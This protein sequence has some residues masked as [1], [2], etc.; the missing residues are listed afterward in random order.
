LELLFV[1]L[2]IVAVA[3]VASLGIYYR[4]RSRRPEGSEIGE[5]QPGAFAALRQEYKSR[6]EDW[7]EELGLSIDASDFPSASVHSLS[8]SHLRLSPDIKGG[9]AAGGAEGAALASDWA[10]VDQAVL[11]GYARYVND[12][13]VS[14]LDLYRDA[15]GR[16][17][18]SLD[19]WVNGLRG[20]VAEQ[21]VFGQLGSWIGDGLTIPSSGSF[22]GVDATILGTD[23]N[24]KAT[25]DVSRAAAEHFEKYPDVP[26][27]VNAD[28]PNMPDSV[29]HIDLSQPFDPASLNPESLIIV[30]DG[31][32]LSGIVESINDVAGFGELGGDMDGLPGIGFVI[33]AARSGYREGRLLKVHG[34]KTR[35]VKNVGVDTAL[36]GGGGLAGAKAGLLAGGA[37]D[38]ATG[39]L[40]LGMGALIG[41]IVGALGGGKAGAM[42]ANT[43]RTQELRS[44]QEQLTAALDRYGSALAR[45]EHE[46]SRSWDEAVRKVE[47]DLDVAESDLRTLQQKTSEEAGLLLRSTTEISDA[48]AQNLLIAA[49]SRV[50][51]A[52]A[53]EHTSTARRRAAAWD[54]ASRGSVGLDAVM[55]VILASP[56]GTQVVGAWLAGAETARRQALGVL[57]AGRELVRASA[58]QAR[59]AASNTLNQERIRLQDKAEQE[60]ASHIAYVEKASI[61]VEEEAKA[62]GMGP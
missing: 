56:G 51:Q 36:I 31:L 7:T 38:V 16:S 46:T 42:A 19:G 57:A 53:R 62:L 52:L 9:L 18:D 35:L 30:A 23:F 49:R 13:M 12:E 22:P 40:T 47:D 28:A 4:S 43:L 14:I 34:D 21:E 2:G 1:I 48:Q 39:G 8:A 3:T 6:P 29:T 37:V 15:V 33:S 5:V 44:R 32:E 60:L 45:L 58:T 59:T 20:H 50:D 54:A 27:I 55:D 24:V 17:G 26:L 11:D 10:H 41:G 61:R 25:N